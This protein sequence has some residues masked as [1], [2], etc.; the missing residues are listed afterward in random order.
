MA[1]WA[2]VDATLSQI[3]QLLKES[4]SPDTEVQRS[5]EQ[6]NMNFV[7]DR[8]TAWFPIHAILPSWFTE[9]GDVEPV[10]RFQ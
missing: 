8:S 10:S 9:A 1:A 6:V 4:H 3:V 5:V 2:P 7:V